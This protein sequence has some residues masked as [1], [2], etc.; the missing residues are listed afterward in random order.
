MTTASS[1]TRLAGAASR[2]SRSTTD[3]LRNAA[4][5]HAR[6]A[7]SAAASS[8]RARVAG[9]TRAFG[10]CESTSEA[11]DAGVAVEVA[12]QLLFEIAIVGNLAEKSFARCAIL[13]ATWRATDLYRP[14]ISSTT[15]S[16]SSGSAG[17]SLSHR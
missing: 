8:T 4:P 2:N 3:S 16:P 15:V 7:R 14:A 12:E 9:A 1:A 6:S 5:P 11:R 17:I 13:T 10:C